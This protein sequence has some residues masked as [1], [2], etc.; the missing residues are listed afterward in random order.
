M[1]YLSILYFV[2]IDSIVPTLH[3]R[4]PKDDKGNIQWPQFGSS[5]QYLALD[6]SEIH[7][8]EKPFEER[9]QFIESLPIKLQDLEPSQQKKTL[10]SKT[11]L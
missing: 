5:K 10:G 11:E 7:I 4:V 8:K 1:I 6:Q 9:Y 2:P 3:F